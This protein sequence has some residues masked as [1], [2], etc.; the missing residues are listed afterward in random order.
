[1]LTGMEFQNMTTSVG[2]VENHIDFDNSFLNQPGLENTLV[3]EFNRGK[4]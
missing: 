2:E 3:N 4:V 1:M